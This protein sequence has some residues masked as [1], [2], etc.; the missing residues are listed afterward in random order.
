MIVKRVDDTIHLRKLKENKMRKAKLKSIETRKPKTLYI[1][2]H[3]LPK[4]IINS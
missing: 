4:D 2:T 1:Y 3:I